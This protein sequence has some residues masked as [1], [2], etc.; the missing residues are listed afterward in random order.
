MKII[1]IILAECYRE[2]VYAKRY[3]VERISS[4]IMLFFIFFGIVYSSTTSFQ[5]NSYNYFDPISTSHRIVGFLLWFFALDAVGH[6]SS[7]I[8]EDLHI[9]ILEQIALSPYSLIYNL[10]GR[11]ISRLIIN[12][13]LS[14]LLFLVFQKTFDVNIKIPL[15]VL[16]FFIL[17]YSGLYGLGLFF[18]GLTL[19][20]KRL[21]PITTIT[22]FLLLIFTGAIIPLDSFPLYLKL[23]SQTLPM[24]L[25]LSIIK[26]IVFENA[27]FL[28]IIKD[29]KFFLF[30]IN[31]LFYL[32]LGIITF[33]YLEKK[34]RSKGAL[35]TY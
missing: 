3:S 17:T 26:E 9:G 1:S 16:F 29:Y 31:S 22:R 12:F 32:S 21:G 13:T 28:K 18:A 14:I 4:L 19:I 8:R 2:F 7:S 27:T 5:A 24:T 30:L 23:F 34:A 11:S 10:M 20:F 35:G 15:V 25:G 6:L 33:L